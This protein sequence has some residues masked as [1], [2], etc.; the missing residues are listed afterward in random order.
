MSCYL[1]QRSTGKWILASLTHLHILFSIL[2]HQELQDVK[3]GKKASVCSSINSLLLSGISKKDTLAWFN[4][5]SRWAR[6]ASAGAY[7]VCL[8]FEFLRSRLRLSLSS[9]D[10]C[11]AEAG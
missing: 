4:A 6:L 5:G 3:L 8:T 7:N 1:R 9:D 2:H 10:N 11:H